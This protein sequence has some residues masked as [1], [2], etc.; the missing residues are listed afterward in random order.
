MGDFEID[1]EGNNLIVRDK[2]GRLNDKEGRRVNTRGYLIDIEGNIITRKGVL[3]F[4]KDEIDTDDEI[5]APFCFEKKKESLFRV[6]ALNI[7]NKKFKKVQVKDEEDEIEK[8][9]NKLKQANAS[10]RSSVDSLMGETPSKYNKKNKKRNLKDEDS[11]LS[12]IVQPMTAKTKGEL[13]KSGVDS[14]KNNRATDNES[15][16]TRESKNASGFINP[17]STT[18]RLGGEITSKS[19]GARHAIDSSINEDTSNNQS[20]RDLFFNALSS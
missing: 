4:R 9:F 10:H 17:Q 6:E 13:I 16:M 18:N 5:P 19:K 3:I 2:D 11:F 12:K 7:Y 20:T 1:D 8:E 14:V 15:Q